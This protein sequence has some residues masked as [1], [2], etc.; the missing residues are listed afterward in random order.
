MRAAVVEIAD[1]IHLELLAGHH[2]GRRRLRLVGLPLILGFLGF[3]LLRLGILHHQK[4]LL[5][6][7]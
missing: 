3:E 5:A 2:P 6:V 1:V 4:D 7:G